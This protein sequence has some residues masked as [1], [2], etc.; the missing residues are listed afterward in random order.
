MCF[1]NTCMAHNELLPKDE[2]KMQ[3]ILWNPWGKHGDCLFYRCSGP[4]LE[5]LTLP[6]P[7]SILSYLVPEIRNHW[8][9][10]R[11]DECFP[12]CQEKKYGS[13]FP[14]FLCLLDIVKLGFTL[15]WEKK[16]VHFVHFPFWSYKPFDV[17]DHLKYHDW[18]FPLGT[19]VPLV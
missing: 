5:L 1:A 17:A 16:T 6:T 14:T 12:R 15:N 11:K 8:K 10:R 2:T 13:L 7:N 19:R 18:A 4:E 9:I 3:S